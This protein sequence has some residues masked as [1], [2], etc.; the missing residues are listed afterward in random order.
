MEGIEW[1]R[2]IAPLLSASDSSSESE[3]S[4]ADS[5]PPS[6][7][8]WHSFNP[9]ENRYRRNI[10]KNL[11]LSILFEQNFIYNRLE[12]TYFLEFFCRR[13]FSISLG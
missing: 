11:C 12:Q 2:L 4:A 9:L 10:L 1:S 3:L 7:T 8:S 5:E 6:T 13:P